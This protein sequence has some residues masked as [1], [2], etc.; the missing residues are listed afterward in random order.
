MIST[1]AESKKTKK[2]TT[3]QEEDVA[4]SPIDLLVDIIIGYMERGS[5]CLRTIGTRAFGFLTAEME[6]STLDLILAVSRPILLSSRGLRNV[7]ATGEP[8]S[9]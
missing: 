3:K 7:V 4:S 5:A 8:F 9:G 2:K 1:F 6:M